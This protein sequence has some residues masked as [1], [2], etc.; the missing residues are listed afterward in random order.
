M[1]T[2]KQLLQE[3]RKLKKQAGEG[4]Q[5]KPSDKDLKKAESVVLKEYFNRSCL[6]E[7][8]LDE[9]C[10][11]EMN[12]DEYAYY[13]EPKIFVLM[14]ETRYEEF[15]GENY[16]KMRGYACYVVRNG[17]ILAEESFGHDWRS[18]GERTGYESAR[19]WFDDKVGSFSFHHS[20]GGLY[21]SMYDFGDY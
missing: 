8:S 1:R 13:A 9:Y 17:K 5:Y 19:D 18:E 12:L 11:D 2:A 21:E 4:S 15:D 3:I 6:R 10:F 7:D 14:Y 20:G 16:S